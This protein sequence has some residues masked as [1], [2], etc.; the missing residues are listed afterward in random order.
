MFFSAKGARWKSLGVA[1]TSG[2]SLNVEG[3][4]R[5]M[6]REKRKNNKPKSKF[7]RRNPN[8]GVSGVGSAVRSDIFKGAASRWR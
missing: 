3:I 6:N 8:Q 5:L 4:R 2:S 7:A 1:E